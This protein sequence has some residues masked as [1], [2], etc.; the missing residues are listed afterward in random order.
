MRG[1]SGNVLLASDLSVDCISSSHR[2]HV[3]LAVVS[4]ALFVVGVS[5][6]FLDLHLLLEFRDDRKHPVFVAL[7]HVYRIEAFFT[8]PL[9]CLQ[10][11]CIEH[12]LGG[13]EAAEQSNQEHG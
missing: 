3:A 7:G 12:E 9:I 2:L 6:T 13:A 10:K 1:V 8:E 5:C 11:V 4:V